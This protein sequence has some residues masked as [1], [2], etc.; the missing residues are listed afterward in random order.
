M[1]LK[2]IDTF[3]IWSPVTNS[4]CKE[5]TQNLSVVTTNVF[6]LL[7]LSSI[8]TKCRIRDLRLDN[9]KSNWNDLIIL[10]L[11]QATALLPEWLFMHYILQSCWVVHQLSMAFNASYNWLQILKHCYGYPKMIVSFEYGSC[12]LYA[13]IH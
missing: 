9:E 11:F 12:I 5:E 2:H 13:N 7:L 8:T 1:E 3:F 4:N 10:Y 6:L